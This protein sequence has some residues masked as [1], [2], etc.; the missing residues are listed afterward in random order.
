MTVD[1]PERGY[2]SGKCGT[3]SWFH[4]LRGTYQFKIVS[5]KFREDLEARIRVSSSITSDSRQ[6]QRTRLD[7]ESGWL[8]WNV[9]MI[10]SSL[11]RSTTEDDIMMIN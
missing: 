7:A 8:V 5:I 11:A 6:V 1:M 3:L 4:D 10:S 9:S 2:Y